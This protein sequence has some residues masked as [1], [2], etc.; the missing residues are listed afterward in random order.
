MGKEKFV[1]NLD[2]IYRKEFL[3][4]PSTLWSTSNGAIVGEVRS[5]GRDGSQSRKCHSC[6]YL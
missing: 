1:S 2:N 4:V 5:A 3:A 6:D